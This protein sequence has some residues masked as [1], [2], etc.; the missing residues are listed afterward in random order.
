MYRVQENAWMEASIFDEYMVNQN[1][2]L[3]EQN[4]KIHMFIDSAP[5]HPASHN[6]S[7]MTMKFFP[8]NSTAKC[9]PGLINCLKSNYEKILNQK[10]IEAIK[11]NIK[12]QI[13]VLDALHYLEQ[14]WDAI[15]EETIRDIFRKAGFVHENLDYSTGEG[16]QDDEEGPPDDEP[17]VKEE[18]FE[19][20]EDNYLPICAVDAAQMN[21]DKEC[22]NYEE[23]ESETNNDSN[24]TSEEAYRSFCTLKRYLAQNDSERFDLIYEIED[25]LDR[26]MMNPNQS[27]IKSYIK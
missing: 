9:Q 5:A 7:N 14:A 16:S 19:E 1:K 15:S 18:E 8:S 21:Y 6:L 10:R 25:E 17:I 20:Y 4:K 13:T 22:E 12:F 24:V 23:N 11:E 27:Q 26:I 3:A 2:K